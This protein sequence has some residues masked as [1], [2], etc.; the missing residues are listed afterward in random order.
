MVF[1]NKYKFNEDYLNTI[2]SER[3]AYFLGLFYA[4]GCL[5]K[6]EANIILT[7]KDSY[8]LEEF[9]KDF[10]YDKPL[11]TKSGK[12]TVFNGKQCIT[13]PQKTFQIFNKRLC[14]TLASFGLCENKSMKIRLPNNEIVPNRFM[15]HFIRG[16]FDGDGSVHV[17]KN[18]N[19]VYL[20]SNFNFCEDIQKYLSSEGIHSSI[21]KSET[22]YRIC[23]QRILD[24]KKFYDLIY[25][26]ASIFLRRKR[27][28]FDKLVLHYD[29]EKPR[30]K[31]EQYNSFRG[32]TF[33]KRKQKW[34]AAKKVKG[35]RNFL[36]YFQSPQEAK[37]AFDIFESSL[38][39]SGIL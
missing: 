30:P 9:R 25:E 31:R 4:D 18:V 35:K 16:Y 36:G 24:F 20:I 10:S 19:M 23:V 22:V 33:D 26:N 7:E 3:K 12:T 11:G 8:L 34:L 38:C 21:Y 39:P 29:W 5:S 28:T 6:Y 32:V 13:K 2:D 15:R 17:A 1:M 14:E 27:D 37:L